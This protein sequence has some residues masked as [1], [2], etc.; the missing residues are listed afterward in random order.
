MVPSGPTK[1]WVANDS[2]VSAVRILISI[3]VFTGVFAN[4]ERVG[5]YI[6]SGHD[7]GHLFIAPD[8]S[9]LLFGD[10]ELFVSYPTGDNTWSKP[11]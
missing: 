5:E 8:K 1:S 3:F 7:Y 10:G 11:K 6:Y 9:Y 4:Q 2:L